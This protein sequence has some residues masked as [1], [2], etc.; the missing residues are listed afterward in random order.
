[1]AQYKIDKEGNRVLV[2]RIKIPGQEP[3]VKPESKPKAKPEK[4]PV[5]SKPKEA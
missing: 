4:P 1:M 5:K 2:G 3:K